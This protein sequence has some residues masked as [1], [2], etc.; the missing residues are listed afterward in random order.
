MLICSLA[1]SGFCIARVTALR[2]RP[3]VFP[4]LLVTHVQWPLKRGKEP[5]SW[6]L[7]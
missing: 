3:R 4:Y 5:S 6:S 7:Q 2:Q 1:K